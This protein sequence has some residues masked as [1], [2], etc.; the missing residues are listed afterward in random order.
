MIPN[1]ESAGNEIW[2]AILA[3]LYAVANKVP[4]PGG[5]GAR[6]RND[7]IA[8][9]YSS[10]RAKY[11]Q[12]IDSKISDPLLKLVAYSILIYED[13]CRP[14]AI[15]EIERLA[16]WKKIRTTGIMQVSSVKPLTDA[17]SLELG[18]AKLISKWQ[19]DSSSDKYS[20]IFNT[21]SDYNKDDDYIGRVMEVM[22]ILSERIDQNF[23]PVYDSIW[24]YE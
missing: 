4:L 9:H 18:L 11:G 5:P 19:G 8:I 12:I 24:S 22:Q 10:A 23:K 17:E 13:Y 15:R 7:F 20:K 21:I 14:P 6:R 2:L 3:F 16:W 1:L